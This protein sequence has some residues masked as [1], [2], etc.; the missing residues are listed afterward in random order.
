MPY[1]LGQGSHAAALVRR[2]KNRPAARCAAGSQLI[3]VVIP[4]YSRPL[5]RWPSLSRPLCGPRHFREFPCARVVRSV[6]CR[7]SVFEPNYFDSSTRAVVRERKAE[8]ELVFPLV[9]HRAGGLPRAAAGLGGQAPPFEGCNCARNFPPVAWISNRWV[10]G[11]DW[12]TEKPYRHTPIP[13]GRS[14]GRPTEHTPVPLNGH[15]P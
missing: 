7:S 14:G 10:S 2:N 8:H 3:T 6:R 15:L 13:C 4:G 11:Y 12:V 1:E 9:S 5:G